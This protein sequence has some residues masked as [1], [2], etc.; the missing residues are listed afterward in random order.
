MPSEETAGMARAARCESCGAVARNVPWRPGATCPGCGSGRYLPVAAS[1][2]SLDYELADRSQGYA[3][4]DIR[5]GKI[6]QWCGLITPK[7]YALALKRQEQMADGNGS[8]PPL[9]DVLVRDGAL[10]KKQVAIVLRVRS[11]ARPEDGDNEFAQLAVATGQLSREQA[12]AC[13]ELQN[14]MAA[15]GRDVPPLCLLAY[16]KRYLQENQVVALLRS[17]A[18]DGSGLVQDMRDEEEALRSMSVLDR[19]VGPKG[20]PHRRAKL[21][22]LTFLP[23]LVFL[24]WVRHVKATDYIQALCESCGAQTTLVYKGGWPQRCPDC[25]RKAAYPA[26]VCRK[27]GQVFMVKNPHARGVRCPKCKS[28]QW[29][30]Y[31]YDVIAKRK[32]AESSKRNNE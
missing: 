5:F 18:R 11:R 3:L 29:D 23:V 1:C 13:A 9:G 7:Q 15:E 24:M 12:A 14:Q 6:A 8:R 10:S 30:L 22:V 32:Q 31:R 17:Q 20:T 2:A 21:V 25:G 4:E 26:A 19:I 28:D 27:C 16:E